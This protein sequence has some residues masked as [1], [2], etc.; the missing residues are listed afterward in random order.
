MV[1]DF[2][3]NGISIHA[4]LAES[5]GFSRPLRTTKHKFLSTL[6]LRRA[7]REPTAVRTPHHRFLSTLSLR[8]ATNEDRYG[9][10]FWRFLSTLSLRRATV[11]IVIVVMYALI[12]IHALLAESDRAASVTP[13]ASRRFLSTLSLRR[14]TNAAYGALDGASISIHALLAESDNDSRGTYFLST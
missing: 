5:D 6:S 2:L 1:G 4:L 14:A 11:Q 7:T 12:S 10:Q 9:Q 13:T 8:R 3:I